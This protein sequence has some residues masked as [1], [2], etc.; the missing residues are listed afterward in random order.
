[1]WRVPVRYLDNMIFLGEGG[2]CM[3]D[4]MKKPLGENLALYPPRGMVCVDWSRRCVIHQFL[5]DI[6]SWKYNNG[7]MKCPV[8]LKQVTIVTRDPWSAD[9][10][11]DIWRLPF[12]PSILGCLCCAM[13]MAFRSKCKVL[14]DYV[15]W[16]T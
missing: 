15:E 12:S 1:V 14:Q 7:G 13:M 6:F 11:E 10:T 4:E 2:L 5:F 8:G 3:F 9:W 16:R